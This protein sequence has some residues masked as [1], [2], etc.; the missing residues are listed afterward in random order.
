MISFFSIYRHFLL[1]MT[2]TFP[3]LALAH[4]PLGAE[5]P[6]GFLDGFL[7]GVGHPLIE[8]KH[9]LFLLGFSIL[10]AVSKI[11][12]SR[13]WVLIVAFLFATAVGTLSAVNE[14]LIT[15]LPIAL[16]VSMLIMGFLLWRLI[17]PRVAVALF[18]LVAGFFHGLAFSETVIGAEA[19]PI[20]AYIIGLM[21]VQIS[22]LFSV[23]TLIRHCRKLNPAVMESV[24]SFFAAVLVASGT[25]MTFGF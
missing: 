2:M 16:A 13:A 9:A 19:T 1:G 24:P 7:S 25:I 17:I 10:L 11:A 14:L 21:L 4:H 18:M 23:F 3:V 6:I 22:L 8:L 5:M 15:V 12:L 20:L